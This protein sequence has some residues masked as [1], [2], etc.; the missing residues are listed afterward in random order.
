[1]KIIGLTGTVGSGKSTVGK[2]MQDNFSV[3]LIM[4]DDLGH[5]AIEKG[6]TGYQ[7]V[8]NLFGTGILNTQGEIDRKILG[9]IVF[10]NEE[11][12]KKLNE[13]I[14]PWVKDYLAEDIAKEIKAD[15]YKFYIIESAILFETGL[16]KLCQENWYIDTDHDIRKE[17][18][19]A[20]RGY[21]DEKI[22]SI[23]A[24]QKEKSF[25]LKHCD[26]VIENNKDLEDVLHQIEKLLV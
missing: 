3:K 21:S 4:T 20:S 13:I 14:H 26:C 25:F 23:L 12:L 10:G 7:K 2:L 17:R 5:L 9:G 15:R 8:I 22:E 24:N 6:N 11:K 18:L 19:R 1:M 16:N